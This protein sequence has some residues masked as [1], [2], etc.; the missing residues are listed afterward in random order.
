MEGSDGAE[1]AE[2]L[3]KETEKTVAACS[4]KSDGPRDYNWLS[5]CGGGTWNYYKAHL[6]I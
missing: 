3:G 6:C 2:I 4:Y 1:S 5:S